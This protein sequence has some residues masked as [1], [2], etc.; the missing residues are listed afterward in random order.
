ML[1][2]FRCLL[3]LCCLLD[4]LLF[5]FCLF[6]L[7]YVLIFRCVSPCCFLLF[8]SCMLLF[9]LCACLC[10]SFVCVELFVCGLLFVC[11]ACAVCCVVRCVWFRLVGCCFRL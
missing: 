7:L 2:C 11:V 4:R 8:C 10:V 1:V 9:L 5:M 3:V 6:V